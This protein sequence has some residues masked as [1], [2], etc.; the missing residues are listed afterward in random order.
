MENDNKYNFNIPT[1]WNDITL[2]TWQEIQK[3]YTEKENITIKDILQIL[4]GKSKEEIDQL[5]A[6]IIN[7]LINN[8]S[9]LTQMPTDKM[10]NEVI[11][12]GE[13]YKVKTET[14]MRF[15][16]FVDSQD[17]MQRD[18]HNYAALF[19][20]ICRKEDEE[21]N[22][23][24]IEKKFEERVKIFEDAKVTDIYPVISFFF[25][26]LTLS[27][28]IIHRYTDKM[29]EAGIRLVDSIENS[30]NCGDGKK[31]YTK[32]QMKK[33]HKLKEYLKSI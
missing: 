7:K 15:G 12:N 17:I 25:Q 20:V 23:D 18:K 26:S 21:Y 28:N 32:S 14:E 2:K 10:T 9:F 4:I 11:I 27:P 8:L 19:A 13:K 5:P 3:I 1:S 29:K 30:Q 33:L 31:L 24:F 22:D 6:S 16:E